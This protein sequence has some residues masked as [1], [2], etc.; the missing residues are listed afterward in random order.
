MTIQYGATGDLVGGTTAG[1]AQRDLGQRRQR[2]RHRRL[3]T[4]DNVVEGDYIGT[5]AAG[6]AALANG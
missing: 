4:R 1:T 3:D 6:T 5:N 2:R